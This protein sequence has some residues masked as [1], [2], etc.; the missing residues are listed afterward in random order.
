MLQERDGPTRSRALLALALHD[1]DWRW[2]QNLSLEL[3]NDPDP[4]MRGTA[5][6]ALAHLARIHRKLDLDKVLPEL[7]R[8]KHDAAISGR[9]EDA[10]SDIEI[11]LKVPPAG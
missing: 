8:L 5:V 4:A 1:E 7:K 2:V 9:V 10:L 6:L 3:I 11:F